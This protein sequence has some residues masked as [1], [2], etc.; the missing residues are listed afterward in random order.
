MFVRLCLMSY[1]RSVNFGLSHDEAIRNLIK[2]F[3]FNERDYQ[4]AI[5]SYE[6]TTKNMFNFV[7]FRDELQLYSIIQGIHIILSNKFEKKDGRLLLK[8]FL[9]FYYNY[10]S[11]NSDESNRILK[12]FLEYRRR[13]FI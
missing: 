1:S 6:N 13:M 5:S 7:T 3:C 8:Y 12:T 2:H 11:D 9:Q 10:K 4:I